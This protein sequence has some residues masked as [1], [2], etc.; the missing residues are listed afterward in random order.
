M[1]YW[2]LALKKFFYVPK[3]NRFPGNVTYALVGTSGYESDT[4]NEDL[5]QAFKSFATKQHVQALAL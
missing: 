1:M 3:F 4:V 5:L 2:I